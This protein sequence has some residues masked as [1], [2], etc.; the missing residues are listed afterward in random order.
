MIYGNYQNQGATRRKVRGDK[1]ILRG[2]FAGFE[3]REY[4][5]ATGTSGSDGRR[6]G[7]KLRGGAAE[8]CDVRFRMGAS[9]RVTEQSSAWVQGSCAFDDGC[10]DDYNHYQFASE[11]WHDWNAG[12]LDAMRRAAA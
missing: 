8:Q 2:D 1:S 10:S 4:N 9:I 7:G 6:T 3:H 11:G 5:E 12:Y